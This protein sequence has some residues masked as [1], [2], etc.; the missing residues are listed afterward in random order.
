MHEQEACR[1]PDGRRDPYIERIL[2]RA[3]TIAVVGASA[4]PDR[5]A[6]DVFKFLLQQ[7]RYELFAVNPRYEQVL[8]VR[9]YDDLSSIGKHID[10]VDVFRRSSR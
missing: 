4:K 8:G 6:H 7:G 5:P 9:C 10:I 3:K 2:T 1:I